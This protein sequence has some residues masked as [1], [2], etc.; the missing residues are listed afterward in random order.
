MLVFDAVCPH[1]R[2]GDCIMGCGL[3]WV[4]LGWVMVWSVVAHLCFGKNR[5]V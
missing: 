3:G 5:S 1:V 4:G 2:K